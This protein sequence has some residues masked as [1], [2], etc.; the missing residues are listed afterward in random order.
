MTGFCDVCREE[1][2]IIEDERRF[3]FIIK[4]SV[5]GHYIAWKPKGIK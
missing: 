3:Y 1:V 5:C 2:K 4:C